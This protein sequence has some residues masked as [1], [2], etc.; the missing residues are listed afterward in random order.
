MQNLNC[1]IPKRKK[2]KKYHELDLR[3]IYNYNI[4]IEIKLKFILLCEIVFI[5][6]KNKH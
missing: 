6:V 4:S 2:P 1:S 3:S 5:V